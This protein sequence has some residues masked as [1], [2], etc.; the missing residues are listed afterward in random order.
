MKGK[1]YN[2]ISYHHLFH[3]IIAN[4]NHCYLFHTLSKWKK[5]TFILKDFSK[6][7]AHIHLYI[8]IPSNLIENPFE[9]SLFHTFEQP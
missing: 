2:I 8:Y 6:I 3:T 7:Y 5:K 9:S 4:L 1:H